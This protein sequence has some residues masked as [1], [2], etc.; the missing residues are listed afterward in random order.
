MIL[1]LGL[2]ALFSFHSVCA[3]DKLQ[4]GE[5]FLVPSTFR[6]PFEFRDYGEHPNLV[7]VS[8]TV[9]HLGG[10]GSFTH[11]LLFGKNP[12]H[13]TPTPPLPLPPLQFNHPPVQ[14][15]YNHS[16]SLDIAF[17]L[18]ANTSWS[19]I[20]RNLSRNSRFGTTYQTATPLLS[21]VGPWQGAY[22]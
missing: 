1:A 6:K 4:T 17:L 18:S 5:T 12:H 21:A 7:L 3:R 2:E 19:N 9:E 15:A 10:L 20:N 14:A 8:T 22:D 11:S 13:A 16:T